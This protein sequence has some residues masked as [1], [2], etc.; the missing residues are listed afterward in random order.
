ML[1]IESVN[2]DWS[3]ERHWKRAAACAV[4]H[5]AAAASRRSTLR[6]TAAID[7]EMQSCRDKVTAPLGLLV[8]DACLDL[9]LVS[10][11]HT[12]LHCTLLSCLYLARHE[13]ENECVYVTIMIRVALSWHLC[14]IGSVLEASRAH[15]CLC[16]SV[17]VYFCLP[18]NHHEAQCNVIL[19]EAELAEMLEARIN[20]GKSASTSAPVANGKLNIESDSIFANLDTDGTC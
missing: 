8:T 10:T 7:A 17:N 16:V 18:C 11:A 13:L 2:C 12:D 1:S 15:T 6:H 9:N 14:V 19:Q 3:Q 5:E 20:S 4:A